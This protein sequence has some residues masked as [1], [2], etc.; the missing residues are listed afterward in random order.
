MADF[1]GWKPSAEF[2]GKGDSSLEHL[3]RPWPANAPFD[4]VET[5]YFGFAIPE[6]NIDC[7]IYFWMHPV[8]GVTSGGVFCFQGLKSSQ[9]EADYINYFNYMPLP[10]D[11]TD[12]RYP[13]GLQVKM[14]EASKRFEIKYSDPAAHT[15]FEFVSTAVMPL[16]FRP[17][18]GHFTQAMHNRGKLVLRGR[19]YT[20]DSY[21]S[22][23]RSWGDPRAEGQLD[24][25]PVGW[26]VA[27]FSDDLAFHVIAF[28]GPDSSP[29]KANANHIWGYVWRDEKLLGVR[30][31]EKRTT[32]PDG[33]FPSRIEL[34]ILDEEDQ[35]HELIG[36]VGARYPFAMWPNA[37]IGYSFTHWTY[38]GHRGYG[39]TQEA[40]Y[41][42]FLV[43]ALGSSGAAAATRR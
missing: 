31:C 27:V 35:T 9:M 23:D 26:H 3:R 25:S 19:E 2:F 15:H 38:K 1:L 33:V 11:I 17:T 30:G 18:G 42:S 39:D 40:Y 29:S 36:T 34:R 16:A 43:R 8:L 22:R 41:N 37:T 4:L 32:R 6:H 20:I 28:D 10:E 13:M 24:V 5:S 12:V 21:F 7:E 14:L